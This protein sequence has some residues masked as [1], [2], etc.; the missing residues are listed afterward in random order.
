MLVL[1]P[2]LSEEIGDVH[3]EPVGEVHGFVL[4]LSVI[5]ARVVHDEVSESFEVAALE[6]PCAIAASEADQRPDLAAL[7]CRC[8]CTEQHPRRAA[9]GEVRASLSCASR[10]SSDAR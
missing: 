3:A 1:R 4:I 7:V 8:V 2:Q 5:T 10:R 9:R 6:L